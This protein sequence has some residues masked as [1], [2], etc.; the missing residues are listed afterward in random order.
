[1]DVSDEE[2]GASLVPIIE[3]ELDEITTEVGGGMATMSTSLN[4]AKMT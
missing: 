4:H 1:M 2:A 3:E